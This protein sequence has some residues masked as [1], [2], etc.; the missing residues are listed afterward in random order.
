MSTDVEILR[1]IAAAFDFDEPWCRL[2]SKP[3]LDIPRNIVLVLAADDP[4]FPNPSR[5]AYADIGEA[6][7][8]DSLEG[9]NRQT[10]VGVKGNVNKDGQPACRAVDDQTVNRRGVK[11]RYD[12]DFDRIAPAAAVAPALT[13][14]DPPRI[15]FRDSVRLGQVRQEQVHQ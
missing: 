12:H 15:V 14:R 2:S 4:E 6:D 3:N 7:S 1:N 9:T 10:G 13:S 5:M 8:L 11:G